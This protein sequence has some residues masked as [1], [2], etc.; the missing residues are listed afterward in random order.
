MRP[1]SIINDYLELKAVESKFTSK[2][3]NQTEGPIWEI[4]IQEG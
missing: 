1:G 3:G 2:V 4:M